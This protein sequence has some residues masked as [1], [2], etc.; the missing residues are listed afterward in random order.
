MTKR[1]YS[2]R[3]IAI[4]IAVLLVVT[5]IVILVVK[6]I[7]NNNTTTKLVMTPPIVKTNTLIPCLNSNFTLNSN[8]KCEFKYPGELCPNTLND[9]FKY[10]Y[11]YDGNCYRTDTC[12]NQD[13]FVYQPSGTG[14]YSSFTGVN[15]SPTGYQ[16]YD[17]GNRYQNSGT[18]L[19]CTLVN[20]VGKCAF[21]KVGAICSNITYVNCPTGFTGMTGLSTGCYSD[22]WKSAG[23]TTTVS[24]SNLSSKQTGQK[25]IDDS[26][27]WATSTGANNITG[28]YGGA[29]SMLGVQTIYDTNGK[30]VYNTANPLCSPYFESNSNG[31][32]CP[33][34][35]CPVGFTAKNQ[36]CVNDLYGKNCN[37]AGSTGFYKYDSDGNCKILSICQTGLNQSQYPGYYCKPGNN[38]YSVCPSGYYCPVESTGPIICP[39][40]S[41]CPKQGLSFQNQCPAGSFCPTSG[42]ST[43]STCPAGT[44]C[45]TSGMSTSP[46]CPAGSYCPDTKTKNECPAGYYCPGKNITGREN[47]CPIG[48]YTSTTGKSSCDT[49][50]AGTFTS[51]SLTA[52]TSCQPWS[53]G[54][55]SPSAGVGQGLAQS[56]QPGNY[57]PGTT[58]NGSFTG[59][60][61]TG[62][63]SGWNFATKQTSCPI[64]SHCPSYNMSSAPDCPAGY[65]CPT[66]TTQYGC[67]AGYYCPV[68]STSQTQCDKDKTSG[69]LA[70][71]CD[72]Y[73]NSWTKNLPSD[74]LYYQDSWDTVLQNCRSNYGSDTYTTYNSNQ[75]SN[76]TVCPANSYQY[77]YPCVVNARVYYTKEPVVDFANQGTG[78]TTAVNFPGAYFSNTAPA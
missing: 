40:G 11:S 49:C 36:Q 7:K 75:S 24:Y 38:Y 53:P 2:L 59:Q 14:D 37:Q 57:S 42:L 29:T 56:S 62:N 26:N 28:C 73:I 18:N 27:S 65:Y 46:D 71:S 10:I 32:I 68:G 58:V 41:Y 21:G 23:C 69:S 70:S 12:T 64:G 1:K 43:K 4:F 33:C 19:Y 3:N 66:S 52:Q 30:C 60:V 34:C 31:L 25:L 6:S 35:F 45:P 16:C 8:N 74:C 51:G 76:G 22:I 20:P 72:F 63:S 77:K 55:Y 48:K 61:Y 17:N 44:Y 13:N 5:V 47:P 54:Y 15:P 78:N 9:N 39:T 50:P 67:Q